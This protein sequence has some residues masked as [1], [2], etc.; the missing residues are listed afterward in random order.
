M[1]ERESTR[2]VY[3]FYTMSFRLGAA[4]TPD[5]PERTAVRRLD[6]DFFFQVW[7]T[8]DEMLATLR[9][10]GGGCWTPCQPEVPEVPT[11]RARYP[12]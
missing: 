5:F 8:R 6:E 4:H 7:P 12:R 3:H 10:L 2:L 1:A 11:W 9:E